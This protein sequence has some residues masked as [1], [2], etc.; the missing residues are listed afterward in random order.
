MHL[1][2]K[3]PENLLFDDSIYGFK[4]HALDGELICLDQHVDYLSVLKKG[5][6]TL[7]D[8]HLK[9]TQTIE[10]DGDYILMIENN[11]AVLFR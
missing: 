6:L 5:S 1:K 2:V 10:L 7:L 4:A 8:D 3:G 9:E 11:Q